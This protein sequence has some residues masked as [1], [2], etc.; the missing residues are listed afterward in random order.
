MKKALVAVFFLGLIAV[1]NGCETGQPKQNK[2]PGVLDKIVVD[3][4][5]AD[6]EKGNIFYFS[7]KGFDA[8]GTEV[9]VPALTWSVESQY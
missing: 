9:P 6:V 7:A 1:F 3:P 5:S 4:A 8:F 2:I